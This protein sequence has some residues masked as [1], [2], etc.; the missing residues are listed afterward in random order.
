[1]N[2][3]PWAKQVGTR[4][5]TILTER[6]NPHTHVYVVNV[7]V[8]MSICKSVRNF[9]P[10]YL[11]TGRTELAEFFIGKSEQRGLF[12]FCFPT[13]SG[14]LS[15]NQGPK[16]QLFIQISPTSA[17]GLSWNC[18]HR[19]CQTHPKVKNCPKPPE[20]PKLPKHPTHTRQKCRINWQIWF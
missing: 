17:M 2:Y 1:M 10:N 9:G 4:Y 5:V 11:K 12:P 8:T 15:R 6:K 19:H 3:P 13:A 16:N 14:Q 18:K 20:P 7:F